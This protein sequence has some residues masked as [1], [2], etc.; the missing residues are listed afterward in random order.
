MQSSV[1]LNIRK[2]FTDINQNSKLD[3]YR[4]IFLIAEAEFRAIKE[5]Y[6][7]EILRINRE[8]AALTKAASEVIY[9]F[10]NIIETYNYCEYLR[11][12]E[13]KK[14]VNTNNSYNEIV[15]SKEDSLI[16]SLIKQKCGQ[17]DFG[18]E[19]VR[20]ELEKNKEDQT[21]HNSMEKKENNTEV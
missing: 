15:N 1:I 19:E 5:A 7:P 12:L 11:V 21:C 4:N 17:K 10:R 16:N 3:K 9:L 8:L 6:K 14:Y 13:D 2:T 20:K 18:T